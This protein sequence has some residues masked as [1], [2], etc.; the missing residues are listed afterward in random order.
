[1]YEVGNIIEIST[2]KLQLII[3]ISFII[4]DSSINQSVSQSLTVYLSMVLQ[5]FVGPWPLFQ[6]LNLLHSR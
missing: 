6:F 1:M 2:L 4:Q 5:P 3:P